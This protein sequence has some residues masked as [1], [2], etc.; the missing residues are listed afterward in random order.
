MKLRPDFE[1]ECLKEIDTGI[2]S[3]WTISEILDEINRDRSEHWQNYTVKDW[4][5][6]WEEWCEGEI[7]E[8]V[9]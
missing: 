3:E 9:K 5:D 2:Y 8:I 4:R 7:W 6:G 1:K